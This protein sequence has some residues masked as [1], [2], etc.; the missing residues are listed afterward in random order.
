MVSSPETSGTPPAISA[1]SVEVPPMSYVMAF[2][3]PDWARVAAAAITPE[4]GPDI[5]VL[6]AASTTSPAGTVPPL[7]FITRRSRAKPCARNSSWR[8]RM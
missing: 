6:A 7:P 3:S 2:F 5:T 8:R 4:A 1:T